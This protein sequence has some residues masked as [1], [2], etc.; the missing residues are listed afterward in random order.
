MEHHLRW[1]V[2]LELLLI[3]AQPLSG[4]VIAR[5]IFRVGTKLVAQQT[6]VIAKKFNNKRI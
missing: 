5:A 2:N 1:A 4:R 6:I 3:M